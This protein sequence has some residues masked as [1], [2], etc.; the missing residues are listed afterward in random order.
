VAI[1][2]FIEC[3]DVLQV[4]DKFRIDVS[5]SYISKGEE[6]ITLVEV[7]PDTGLGFIDITG[8]APL[9]ANNWVL[10]WQYDT[11]GEKEISV[12]ITTDDAPVVLTKTVNVL[13]AAED[14]LFSSDQE[15]VKIESMILKYVPK[16]KNTFKYIHREAQSQILEWLYLNG[17]RRY[18]GARVTKENVIEL[19]NVKYWATYVAMRLINE[20][21]SNIP[22]DIFA[23]KAAKYM[24]SEHKARENAL[25]KLDLNNDGT[26][27]DNEG[28]IMTTRELVRT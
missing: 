14:R 22:D 21:L 3:D 28:Y 9:S 25:L 1:F 5:K 20:D 27:G 13:T 19:E 11:S 12:R 18:D 10:D 6:P 26:Q 7:E 15:L 16:G 17:Y 24:A 8:A 4:D 2:A 23:Q